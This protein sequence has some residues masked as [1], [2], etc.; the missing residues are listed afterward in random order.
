[1]GDFAIAMFADPAGNVTGLING[2]D[3]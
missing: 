1:M 3:S 2:G